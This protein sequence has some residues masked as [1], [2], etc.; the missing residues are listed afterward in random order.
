VSAVRLGGGGARGQLWR[1]IQAGIYGQTV[2]VLTAEEGGAF[3]SALLAGVGAG[4][5][6]NLDEA[7][8]QAIEVAKRI[9][10][11][12]DEMGAYEA[13]YARW[14]KLYPALKNLR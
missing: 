9:E 1:E 6:A 14:R 2:E 5:W 7:C 12:P 8:G 4:H 13:G 11:D 10:P 3:G